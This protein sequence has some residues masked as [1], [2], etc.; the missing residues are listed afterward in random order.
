MFD[1][2]YGPINEILD[3]RCDMKHSDFKVYWHSIRLRTIEDES[4]SSFLS[5]YTKKRHRRARAYMDSIVTDIRDEMTNQGVDFP[6]IHA[7]KYASNILTGRIIAMEEAQEAESMK[8][9]KLLSEAL[10]RAGA[11]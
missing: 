5:D 10:R 1:L 2:N 9:I 8:T 3:L 4:M 11:P 7:Q 6:D